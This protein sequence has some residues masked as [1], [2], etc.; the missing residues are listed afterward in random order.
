MEGKSG[1]KIRTLPVSTVS[2]GM[3]CEFT[4]A[5]E[6]HMDLFVLLQGYTLKLSLPLRF[7]KKRLSENDLMVLHEQQSWS[8]WF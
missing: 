7:T 4:I 2:D 3:H 6:K 8:G 5:T 1:Q